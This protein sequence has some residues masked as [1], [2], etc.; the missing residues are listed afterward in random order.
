MST[1]KCNFCSKGQSCKIC[2]GKKKL[3][4]NTIGSWENANFFPDIVKYFESNKPKR[5]TVKKGLREELTQYLGTKERVEKSI[6]ENNQNPVIKGEEIIFI[7][8]QNNED[9]QGVI[10]ENWKGIPD[11]FLLFESFDSKEKDI[12]YVPMTKFEEYINGFVI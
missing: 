2:K 3:T 4:Y 6:K 8:S 11:A 9:Y 10:S 7:R 1:I 5:Y 12:F